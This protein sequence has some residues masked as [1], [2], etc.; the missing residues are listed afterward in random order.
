M[1]EEN[2]RKRGRTGRRVTTAAAAAAV[3]LLAGRGLG[4]GGWGLLPGDGNSLLPGTQQSQTVETKSEQPEEILNVTEDDGVLTVRVHEHTIT[5]EDAEL[6]A[7]QLE[8]KLKSLWHAGDPVELVDDGA[9]KA[10]YDAVV[11]V[12]ERLEIPFE[13]VG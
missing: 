8:E 9:I 13:R 2:E 5:L 3:L 11:A 6:S 10:D 1:A 4:S 12:L 7:E